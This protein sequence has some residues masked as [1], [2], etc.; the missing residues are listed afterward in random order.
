MYSIMLMRLQELRK[1]SRAS[2][3]FIL[4]YFILAQSGKIL[5]QFLSGPWAE[6]GLLG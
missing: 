6:E 1:S 3:C 5:A 2:Y 4:F